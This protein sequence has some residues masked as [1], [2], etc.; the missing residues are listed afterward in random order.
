VHV[1]C[2]RTAR[3]KIS[4]SNKVLVCHLGHYPGAFASRMYVVWL[5]QYICYWPIV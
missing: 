5:A 1:V 2:R 4:F 3:Q